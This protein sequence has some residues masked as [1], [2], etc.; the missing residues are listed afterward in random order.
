VLEG[1][2]SKCVFTGNVDNET[3][4]EM[5]TFG[6]TARDATLTDCVISNSVGLHSIVCAC[7]LKR[8]R[9]V[10]CSKSHSSVKFAFGVLDNY[11]KDTIVHD[12]VNCVFDGITTLNSADRTLMYGN[13]V[14]CTVRGFSGVAGSAPL[15]A[16]STAV[17]TIIAG[18]QPA[19]V[20]VTLNPSLRYCLWSTQS[21]SFA[22]MPE[23]CLR[24]GIRFSGVDCGI[25]ASSKA[26]NS[27][28]EDATVLSL[29]G[30]FDCD[31]CP[32]I[33]YGQLDRGAMECQD[34]NLPGLS[35]IIR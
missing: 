21:G 25:R 11:N 13:V 29:V 15:D 17:N 6:S 22:E 3:D 2:A 14:N 9:F 34:D 10:G 24:G 1:S 32:R 4:G 5:W 19:D 30:E 7:T 33:A 27:A 28:L 18:S 23:G 16:T 31:G 12:V 26:F 8:C 35:V 20:D